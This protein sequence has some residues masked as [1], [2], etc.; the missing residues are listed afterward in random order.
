MGN[1]P[2]AKKMTKDLINHL[3]IHRNAFR[4]KKFTKEFL[5]I[6]K[7]LT[8]KWPKYL[9]HKSYYLSEGFP[10]RVLCR[11][12]GYFG[13]LPRLL[14][15][16]HGCK[17]CEASKKAKENF[18]YKGIKY[19]QKSFLEAVKALNEGKFDYSQT[20]F[21]GFDKTILVCCPVHRYIKMKPHL[22]LSDKVICPKC[23]GSIRKNKV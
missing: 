4:T 17:A 12:H 22:H 3:R 23:R 9:F 6:N 2:K 11:T 14:L 7:A 8:S 10:I 19:N 5:K 18:V 21:R 20:V 13:E 1:I 16:G 15:K